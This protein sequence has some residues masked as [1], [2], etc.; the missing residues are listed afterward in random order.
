MADSRDAAGQEQAPPAQRRLRALAFGAGAFDTIMQLGVVHALLVS[1]GKAPDHVVGISA[2]A[3]NAAALADVL[4]YGDDLPLEQRMQAKVRRL[5]YFLDSYLELPSELLASSL[6]DTFEIRAKE[7]LRPLESPVHLPQERSSRADAVRSK[8]GL[9]RLLNHLLSIRL[10][11]A[12]TTRVIRRVLAFREACER[13][14]LS[15]R[16]TTIWNAVALWVMTLRSFY[17]FGQVLLALAKAAIVGETGSL[18][19]GVSKFFG[20]LAAKLRWEMLENRCRAWAELHTTT[21][22]KIINRP[23]VWSL[24][25]AVTGAAMSVVLFALVWSYPLTVT[26]FSRTSLTRLETLIPEPQL[27]RNVDETAV[28]KAY[29]HLRDVAHRVW[30]SERAQLTGNVNSLLTAL[31][32]TTETYLRHELHVVFGYRSVIAALLLTVLIAMLLEI[33]AGIRIAAGFLVVV[34]L[35]ASW[36]TH[37]TAWF[38]F[39]LGSFATVG[40]LIYQAAWIRLRIM[41]H[42]EIADGFL[43]R[44]V[45]MQTLVRA[46]DEKY[47]GE[48]DLHGINNAAL[49]RSDHVK[50]REHTPEALSKFS[51]PDRAETPCIHVGPVA[52]ELATGKLKVLA[53]SMK[54]VDAL[55][56]ATAFVPLFGAKDPARPKTSWIGASYE[57]LVKGK[58]EVREWMIDGSNV[59]NEPIQPLLDHLRERYADDDGTI[60]TVDVYPVSDL[61]VDK[62]HLPSTAPYDNLVDVGLRGLELKQFR[63]ASMERHITRLFTQALSPDKAFHT[64]AVPGEKEGRRTFVHAGV[65]PIELERPARINRRL[66]RGSTP[67]DYKRIL[68]ETVADGCRASLE[69]MIPRQIDKVIDRFALRAWLDRTASRDKKE[70]IERSESFPGNLASAEAE[71]KERDGHVFLRV[72]IGP[73]LDVELKV[74]PEAFDQLRDLILPRCSGVITKPLPGNNEDEGP[75]LSEICRNCRLNRPVPEAAAVRWNA[76]KSDRRDK[77]RNGADAVPLLDRQRLRLRPERL[78]W[79]QWPSVGEPETGQG[80]EPLGR[81]ELQSYRFPEVRWPLAPEKPV[82]SFLFGGGVF[83]G[84][85]H[86]GVLNAL[87]EAGLQPDLIAGSSVGSIIAAMIAAV[88][89]RDPGERHR[90]ILDL[91]ATFLAIDRL[92]L[93]DRLADFV[94]RFTLRAAEAEFSPRDLDLVLR[95]FDADGPRAFNRRVRRVSAGL[96][97]LVYLSPPELWS[98]IKGFRLQQRASVISELLGDVQEFLDRGGVRQEILGSEPL[99]LLIKHHILKPLNLKLPLFDTF[100]QGERPMFFLATATNLNEGQLE[101]LGAPWVH[102]GGVSLEHGLLASSAFPAVFRPRQAWEVFLKT[103][104]DD[105]YID[106]GTIDNL[107]LDAVA[108]F[109]DEAERHGRIKRRLDVPHLLFTA[110]L[111]VD[112]TT[113]SLDE[114]SLER[115]SNDIVALKRRAS[116]FT[117]NRKIKAYTSLQR[118]LRAIWKLHEKRARWDKG[119]LN[120]EVVAVTPKWLCGTF[121][122][123]PMLGFRRKKQAQSIAHGC[124]STLRTLAQTAHEHP[125]WATAWGI[126]KLEFNFAIEKD[127]RLPSPMLLRPGQ[128]WFRD[129]DHPCPY[130]R[131]A[132]EAYNDKLIEQDRASEALSTM[133][134]HELNE[135][136]RNCGRMSTHQTG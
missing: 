120:M 62:P 27:T 60:K 32:E 23:K 12:T 59:S 115:M 37:S 87:N 10:T 126:D 104:R 101:I 34:A 70:M 103:N 5:R 73:K 13:K 69:T 102:S 56:A 61:P 127:Q 108:R 71:A 51:H 85:F 47:F 136:Y 21:A 50:S 72:D 80:V 28:N 84:V 109:L 132:M 88:F 100:L 11:I 26:T 18:R 25:R 63:D 16:E 4:Q 99:S 43:S 95:R 2:G 86:V 106:G 39:V 33:A 79:P 135:I 53:E 44:D 90:P 114:K 124:A 123:H 128:C 9:I 49:R 29:Q 40:L 24:A 7:P 93:T 121:G 22:A 92:I 98:L 76:D 14:P 119:P 31:P 83:R 116:T 41:E 118:R 68:R 112:P 1:R 6:P 125:R 42:Y 94:R 3:V 105:Y 97:R 74:T 107:P 91:A 20:K 66:S 52:A 82:I 78:E 134:L 46:F 19:R 55:A 110:S 38:I 30:M 111:E 96:E 36:M 8:A 117:Y 64:I 45:L 67:E 65:F 122:F 129:G 131:Q 133:E 130:S 75:G 58:K 35:A 77:I 57:D 15:W 89:N 48:S 54:I 113:E 81:G 17:G